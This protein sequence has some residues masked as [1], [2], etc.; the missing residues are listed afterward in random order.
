VPNEMWLSYLPLQ[1]AAG[2]LD[3]DLAIA[4][5]GQT[6]PSLVDAGLAAPGDRPTS[7][8]LFSAR[9]PDDASPR[10][11]WLLAGV[12]AVVLGG[13]GVLAMALTA[14]ERRAGS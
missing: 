8:D 1:V 11:R 10:S 6:S 9:A 3:Y 2:D 13:F 7:E 4:T 12:V 5:D 14:R